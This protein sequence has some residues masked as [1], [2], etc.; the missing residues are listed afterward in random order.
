MAADGEDMTNTDASDF[1]QE[2]TPF[3]LAQD[4]LLLSKQSLPES[5]LLQSALSDAN[6]KKQDEGSINELGQAPEPL[7]P[8]HPFQPFLQGSLVNGAEVE[9]DFQRLVPD[10][11][12]D[13][14]SI[15]L[16]EHALSEGFNSE[17]A[18]LGDVSEKRVGEKIA[19]FEG[20][21]VLQGD[22]S[23]EHAPGRIEIVDS[24][25]ARQNESSTMLEAELPGVRLSNNEVSGS[26]EVDGL[27]PEE[28]RITGE[29]AISSEEDVLFEGLTLVD[30]ASEAPANGT[31]NLGLDGISTAEGLAEVIEE[32]GGVKVGVE[33]VAIRE[34][35]TDASKESEASQ[36][37]NTDIAL[38]NGTLKV[39]TLGEILS[40][41]HIEKVSRE[42]G[43]GTGEETSSSHIISSNHAQIVPD[44]MGST[45]KGYQGN[46]D[47]VPPRVL[48]PAPVVNSDGYV[49]VL[50]MEFS[51]LPSQSTMP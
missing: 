20:L 45:S 48:K 24:Q 28:E 43:K 46:G 41:D 15:L 38:S 27:S 22:D 9:E 8:E 25:D 50:M 1:V 37:S 32:S 39:E 30:L 49:V 12:G 21:A 3:P 2:V 18:D 16:P 29:S 4:L 5:I 23:E 44:S 17:S 34:S 33:S 13:H 51:M 36:G 40:R 11:G 19:L 42:V 31:V 14:G 35:L 7:A 10:D 47:S 26:S 6:K